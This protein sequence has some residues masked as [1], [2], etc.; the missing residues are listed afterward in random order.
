MLYINKY[1]TTSP[2]LKNWDYGNLGAYFLTF[3]TNKGQAFFG[4]IP[5]TEN[6]HP[7]FCH[8]S[9]IGV[10]AQEEWVNSIKLRTDMNLTM[11]EFIVMPN[12]F[13]GIIHIG[14]NKYNQDSNKTRHYGPQRKNL[15]SI[16][17]G[18]K[19]SVTSRA[20]IIDPKFAWQSGYY[21]IIIRNKNSLH[22][23][24]NY[25][26]NNPITWHADKFHK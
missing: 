13:H 11:D 25:I 6:G 19:S 17:R 3:C 5:N 14:R 2:R 7:I 23:I 4:S 26:R 10:I 9:E 24:Q 12:H 21:D 8:L 15:S 20:I 22:N 18:Y 16:I 1:R